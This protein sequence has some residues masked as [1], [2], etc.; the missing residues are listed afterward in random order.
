MI[1][2]QHL[3]FSYRRKEPLYSDLN[4]TLE[5]GKIYGL[6]GKN[7][8]GKTTLLKNIASLLFPSSGS[9]SVNNYVPR[10]RKPSFL[11]SIYFI[12]EQVYTPSLSAERYLDVYAPF[13]PQFDRTR[14]WQ[15]LADF[16]VDKSLTINDLSTGG[17]KKFIIAF[18]LACNT[19]VVVMDEP[20]NG[21]DIPSK[22]QFRKIMAAALTDDRLFIISTHQTRDLEN[23]IDQ[24][25]ILAEGSVLLN[26]PLSIINEKL[27]FEL[28]HNLPTTDDVLYS[29]SSMLGHAVVRR[30]RDGSDSKV[31]L[32]FLFNVM[33]TQPHALKQIFNR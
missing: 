7:G 27:S 8:A 1:N 33:T 13:Y 22:S 5:S 6:L 25:V 20:T 24:V 21:L 17:Q 32:E 29:E 2:I 31:S 23:L 18:A 28:V 9:V 16:E 4:L 12:P 30:N 10:E 26:A 19:S 3:T 14:F 15:M 11:Q